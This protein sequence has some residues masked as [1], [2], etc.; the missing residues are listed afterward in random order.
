MIHRKRQ[1][2]AAGIF[3]IL[4]LAAGMGIVIWLSGSGLFKPKAQIAYFF[5]EQDRGKQSLLVGAPVCLGD[6]EIGKVVSVEMDLDEHKTIY[7]AEIYNPKT[8]I[9]ANATARIVAPLVGKDVTLAILACGD[10]RHAAADR[11][12][13]IRVGPGP[14][15]ALAEEFD[16]R[17][18]E[19][20]VAT[21][22]MQLDPN[23]K[24][25]LV[26]K[27]HGL[28]DTL[29]TAADKAE[30]E[31]NRKDEKAFL[32]KLHATVESLRQASQEIQDTV[33]RI[34]PDVTETV[35]TLKKTVDQ[36]SP[37]VI[38]SA[39]TLNRIVAKA[40]PEIAKTVEDARQ[41]ALQI[42][43]ATGKFDE[44]GTRIAEASK[45]LQAGSERVRDLVVANQA[46]IDEIVD[47][48][49]LLSATLKA[50]GNEL[51]RKPWLMFN[52]PTKEE[53]R[54]QSLFDAARA[55]SEGATQLDQA[56][57]KLKTVNPKVADPQALQ[58]MHDHL[59]QTFTRFKE[60]EDLLWKELNK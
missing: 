5:A 10:R 9:Y 46:N 25:S 44:A 57:T 2:L 60:V 52:P 30:A 23:N 8:R 16:P 1:E 27:L 21:F 19:S 29:R 11:D 20:I 36:A 38:S 15:E 56:L 43:G 55:F 50:T 35:A 34:A 14:L 42:K 40:E 54:R 45:S 37:Q 4:C 3:T 26:S 13:A 49:K 22:R 33:A 7:G 53:T 18:P 31:L 32:G 59:E 28:T 51:R 24:Q 12:H 58:A 6:V 17:K 48:M 47:N 41:A 39:E